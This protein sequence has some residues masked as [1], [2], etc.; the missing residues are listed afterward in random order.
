MEEIRFKAAGTDQLTH[1]QE[2]LQGSCMS[3]SGREERLREEVI[4]LREE[5][6]RLTLRVDRQ[7][8]QISVLED[9]SERN[10]RSQL[11]LSSIS[12]GE[13]SE[14]E[15][16][17]ENGTPVPGSLGSYCL[18]SEPERKS[19]GE[20]SEAPYSWTFREEVAREIGRFLSRSPFRHQP[21]KFRTR[22]A[23]RFAVHCL[24]HREG[25]RRSGHYKSSSS[26][27]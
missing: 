24:R 6:R 18:V 27:A 22:E 4:S 21:R 25:L 8:D 14:V 17:E 20:R 3:S 19:T 13:T 23:E 2:L 12:E 16:V 15:R 7:G 11:T 10:S 9:L 26:A 1:R 5:L